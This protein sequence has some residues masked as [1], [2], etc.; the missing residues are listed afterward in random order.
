ME[1]DRQLRLA[2][3]PIILLAFII[4]AIYSDPNSPKR[5]YLPFCESR[6]ESVS[7]SNLIDTAAVL[8]SSSNL[9]SFASRTLPTPV[10]TNFALLYS[11][12]IANATNLAIL[13]ETTALLASNSAVEASKLTML[14]ASA[15]KHKEPEGV[16]KIIGLIVAGGALVVVLGWII[17]AIGITLLRLLTLSWMRLSREHRKKMGPYEAHLP[18]EIFNAIQIHIRFKDS[19]AARKNRKSLHG[20]SKARSDT[21]PE[22]V[23]APVAGCTTFDESQ[24]LF[25]VATFHHEMFSKGVNE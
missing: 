1:K 17:G 5:K 25:A 9:L 22:N 19:L 6:T 24:C 21:A 13:A 11:Y 2:Y 18:I 15:E 7:S 14:L 20:R 16:E 23:K 8:L 12:A 10:S 4:A 3:P